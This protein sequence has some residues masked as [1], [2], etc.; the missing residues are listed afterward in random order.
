MVNDHR[1]STTS[2]ARGATNVMS[3]SA[4]FGGEGRGGGGWGEG[5]C[6]TGLGVCWHAPAHFALVC[7]SRIRSGSTMI[8][9]GFSLESCQL[10][11]VENLQVNSCCSSLL[12]STLCTSPDNFMRSAKQNVLRRPDQPARLFMMMASFGA[13]HAPFT[14]ND[15][16]R[17]IEKKTSA[18]NSVPWCWSV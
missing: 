10:G 7:S 4:S 8:I 3:T 14:F 18:A 17:N 5:E 12:L 9:V 1:P 11:Q 2:P 16:G 6:N 15:D 13:S